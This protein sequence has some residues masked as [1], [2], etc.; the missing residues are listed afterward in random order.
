MTD[1]I[2]SVKTGAILSNISIYHITHIRF[3]RHF[4]VRNSG[5]KA[6]EISSLSLVAKKDQNDRPHLS[7]Y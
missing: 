2:L 7:Q 4:L 6:T 5:F 3:R 1:Q